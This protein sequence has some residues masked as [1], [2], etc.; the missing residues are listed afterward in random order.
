MSNLNPPRYQAVQSVWSDVFAR[1]LEQ[2]ETRPD[3]SPTVLYNPDWLSPCLFGARSESNQVAWR[4]VMRQAPHDFQALEKA[5][6]WA[7]HPD[8]I[9]Y[10]SA[11][12]SDGLCGTLDQEEVRLIQ[13]WNEADLE[14]LKENLLGHCFA[15]KKNRQPRSLFIGCT[16]SDDIIAIDN[17]SGRITLE[18]PGFAPSRTLAEDV[19][20]FLQAFQ[21]NTQTYSEASDQ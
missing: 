10:Y 18:R 19:I 12:W 15:K 20:A 3:R 2:F 8:A 13:V 11:Y 16:L 5:L 9:A 7:F 4:P 21:P 14:M 1:F 6:G 17:E